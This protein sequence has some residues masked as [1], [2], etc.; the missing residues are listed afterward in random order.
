M[1][2]YTFIIFFALLTILF[3]NQ[4]NLSEKVIY[5][6][7][8]GFVAVILGLRGNQD[9]YT[10]LYNIAP[11]LI[12]FSIFNE[13]SIQKGIVF[14]FICSLLKF[15]GFN[16]QALFL[17][18]TTL[19]VSIYAYYFKKFTIYYYLAFL[20]YLCHGIQF[21]E[22][23]GLRMGLASAMVLPMIDSLAKGKILRFI[24]L[25][26]LATNLQYTAIL[27]ILV[28]N[29]KRTYSFLTLSSLLCISIF[30]V[31]TGIITDV[32]NYIVS[33]NILPIFATGYL[34]DPYHSFNLSMFHPK[35]FQQMALIIFTLIFINHRKIF[36]SPY[37]SLIYNTYFLSTI[38]YIVFSQYAIYSARFGSHFYSVEPVLIAYMTF[39]FREKKLVY[40]F[41]VIAALII[42]YINYVYLIDKVE[43][44]KF[45]ID[46]N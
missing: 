40:N 33:L 15:F 7:L 6:L 13:L 12:N 39:Y 41:A 19:S 28:F 14:T 21:K 26:F 18:F 17:V 29:F 11:E 9:E 38:M 37:H 27:S 42:A 20:L 43:P 16:S 22:L 32:L 8:A 44:Y 10:A 5:Y 45:L 46:Q 36:I 24:I 23:F 30:A 3:H 4:N 25:V 31:Q 34:V 2:Y 35:T 1:E